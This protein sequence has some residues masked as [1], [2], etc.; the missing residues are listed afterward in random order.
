MTM[1][2]V[3]IELELDE[4]D[5]EE[6][7]KYLREQVAPIMHGLPGF[8][9]GLWINGQDNGRGMSVTIWDKQDQADAMISMFGTSGEAAGGKV[10]R[11]DVNK[12]SASAICYFSPGTLL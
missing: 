11:C 9:T 7:K 2:A 1:H 5:P 8:R 3:V 6:G 12:V 4:V 10:I